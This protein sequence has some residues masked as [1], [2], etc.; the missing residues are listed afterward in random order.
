MEVQA[1]ENKRYLATVRKLNVVDRTYT[2][3]W[4]SKGCTDLANAV[5]ESDMRP[6]W[7]EALEGKLEFSLS[8]V[9]IVVVELL[10]LA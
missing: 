5:A 10:H 9:L 7:N 1:A 2:V 3:D 8:V 6:P 4:E